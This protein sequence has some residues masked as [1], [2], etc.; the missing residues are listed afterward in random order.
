M[1]GILL[2]TCHL[3]E[4]GLLQK[5]SAILQGCTNVKMVPQSVFFKSTWQNC[6]QYL[7]FFFLE[8]CMYVFV[9]LLYVNRQLNSMYGSIVLMWALY[10]INMSK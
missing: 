8:L 2:L 10:S 5:T 4:A 1:H 9:L 6:V 3:S 7:K